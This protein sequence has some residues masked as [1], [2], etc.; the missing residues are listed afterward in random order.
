MP[1]RPRPR[2]V[3]TT[4]P[5]ADLD[6]L[7]SL[8]AAVHLHPGACPVLSQGSEPVARDL[9]RQLGESAPRIHELGE[10]DLS[11]VERLVVVD[12]ADLG[13]LGE[14]GRRALA[15]E[16]AVTVYDHHGQPP[17][18][19]PASADY[20][21]AATGS[22][23][24]FLTDLLR[25]EGTALSPAEA[26]LLAAGIYEDTGL[27]TFTGVTGADFEAARWLHEQGADL[28]LVGRVLRQDLDPEQL[29]LLD[30]ILTRL[31][32][33]PGLRHRVLV[34]AV[35]DPGHTQDAAAVVQRALDIREA[36]GLLVLLQ[37]EARVLCIARAR[38][39]GPDVGAVVGEL[40]GGGHPYAASASLPGVPLA[41]AEE[42]LVAALREHD[43]RLRDLDD[44]ATHRLHTLAPAISLEE[45]GEVLARYPIKRLPV[46][47]GEGRPRGYVDQGLVERARLH[48]LAEATAGEYA[49]H[50]PA[51]APDDG[52]GAASSWILDRDYPLVGLVD[53]DGVL[54][55]LVTRTDLLRA[56]REDFPDGPLVPEAGGGGRSRRD[57]T[58]RMRSLMDT[59]TV[60]DLQ[61]LG[62]VAAEQGV[63]AFLVGG[64]VRDLLMNRRNTDVDL[65]V[66]GDAIALAEAFAA[67]KGYRVHGH[68]RFGTAV[69]QADDGRRLDLATSRIEHYPYPA[70][71]PEVEHGSIKADLFRRDF[72]VNAMAVEVDG[73]AFGRLLDLFGGL[74]D[75]HQATLRVMHSLSFV[76]D[77]TR[78]L[79]GVR[80]EAELGFAIEP[81]T[82]RLAK[83][84]VELGLPGRLSGHRLFRDLRYLLD[85]SA[86]GSGVGRLHRLDMLRFVHAGLEGKAG[87]RAAQRVS[88]G[89]AVLA[90]Y[91][92]LYRSEAVE[93]WRVGL[94]LLLWELD[95]DEL[96]PVLA[97]FELRARAVAELAGDRRQAATVTDTLRRHGGPEGDPAARFEALEGLTLAGCLAL[98]AVVED[99]VRAAISDYLQH[100]RGLRPALSGDD[101]IALGVPA[102]PAVGEWL[103]ELTRARVRGEVGHRE[104]EEA[105]VRAALEGS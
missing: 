57:L 23:A 103:R 5:N 71:L 61:A 63:R 81:Q 74:Q 100:Q 22:N 68:G 8:V 96:E 58:G 29:H 72:T 37:Q 48:G 41:E 99:R 83:R 89:E 85:S 95:I 84:A 42:R 40:G 78:I 54:Q 73:E 20:R 104:D 62:A 24:A 69:V 87:E 2:V 21:S 60:A 49:A 76:E 36:E 15:G 26:T 64:L 34:A 90:W 12:T 7:A 92:L 28:P 94:L 39:E 11:S 38:P 70:A 19:L 44:I 16:L 66:E 59:A 17:P 105:R 88:E 91:R 77:P 43:G 30:Q 45:A 35:S 82:E 50:L 86:P 47:D 33:V 1:D 3:A 97:D 18:D 9:L 51:L 75:L 101:L 53:G 31:R 27:L 56:L 14:L 13:R 93:A 32:P 6:A 67:R 65:V 25:Q 10:V 80:F 52:L 102:G 55:G 98:M 79:R 4:H 46:V